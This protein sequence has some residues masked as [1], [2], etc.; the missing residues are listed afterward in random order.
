[1]LSC[2]LLLAIFVRVLVCIVSP[3]WDFAEIW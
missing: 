3:M 2:T 1:M